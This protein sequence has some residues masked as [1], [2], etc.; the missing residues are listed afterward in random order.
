MDSVGTAP[1]RVKKPLPR[2][3][4]AGPGWAWRL[5]IREKI[6]A[7]L[8]PGFRGQGLSLE[9][10]LCTLICRLQKRYGMSFASEEGLR[11]LLMQDTGHA[12]GVGSVRAALR[13]L[14]RKGVLWMD[15]LAPGQE[16]PDGRRASQGTRIVWW[17]VG[18]DMRR[19]LQARAKTR[20]T[21]EPIVQRTA[22]EILKRLGADMAPRRV[23]SPVDAGEFERRRADQLRRLA[24]LQELWEREAP[25]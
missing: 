15:W 4:R 19:R 9:G 10:P 8:M 3:F 25:A 22:E 6:P 13:R 11:R 18:R 24:E 21:R 7:D 2:G 14:E 12:P 16:L 17:P 5:K 23:A 20:K 1:P